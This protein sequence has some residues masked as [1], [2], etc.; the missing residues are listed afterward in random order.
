[1]NTII[2][3]ITDHGE[4]PVDIYTKLSGNRILFISEYIEDKVATDVVATLLLKDYEDPNQKITLFLNTDGGDI[5]SVFMI[6]DMMQ[7]L[8]SPIETICVGEIFD[9]AVLILAAGTPNM[10]YASQNAIIC[11]S[12]LMPNKYY[13]SDLANAKSTLVRNQKDNKNLMAALASKIG[14]K[15]AELTKDLERPKFMSAREAKKYGI[16]DHI[17]GK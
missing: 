11:P 13:M 6:Y 12:Q 14:K 17:I 10:R 1:M 8:Q 16:V 5:R 3:E 9:E 2:T 15:T 4:V 7:V